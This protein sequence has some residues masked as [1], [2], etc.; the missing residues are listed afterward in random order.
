MYQRH[1]SASANLAQIGF[2]CTSHPAT[3]YFLRNNY[4]RTQQERDP[5]L[6]KRQ[7]KNPKKNL[8]LMKSSK[9]ANLWAFDIRLLVELKLPNLAAD[10]LYLL[11]YYLKWN[12]MQFSLFIWIDV[13]LFIISIHTNV[14]NHFAM[15]ALPAF[16]S[17]PISVD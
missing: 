14:L 8:R 17:E 6:R 1:I 4:I 9:S 16:V 12:L 7:K 5:N 3:T 15:N 11:L 10:Y 13:L 2:L